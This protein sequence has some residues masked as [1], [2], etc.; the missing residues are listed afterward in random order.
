MAH[1]E[2]PGMP[3]PAQPRK[4]SRAWVKAELRRFFEAGREHG[5]LILPSMAAT[6]LDVSPQRVDQLM[7]AGSLRSCTFLGKRFVSSDDVLAFAELERTPS[8]R[9]DQFAA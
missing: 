3:V 5:G 6:A 7:K 1:P 8:F 9:Y 2:F 4:G